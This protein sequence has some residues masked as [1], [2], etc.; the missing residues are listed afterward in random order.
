MTNIIILQG[1]NRYP[2]KIHPLLFVRN[3]EGLASSIINLIRPEGQFGAIQVNGKIIVQYYPFIQI[4]YYCFDPHQH[5]I[6]TLN[7]A[8]IPIIAMAVHLTMI[9]LFSLILNMLFYAVTDR[10]I[11]NL[12]TLILKSKYHLDQRLQLEALTVNLLHERY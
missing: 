11:H 9:L 3:M 4:H 8:I 10:S 5:S 2:H 7:L 6:E 1:Q 12:N